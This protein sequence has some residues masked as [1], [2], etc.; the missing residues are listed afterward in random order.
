M[1]WTLLAVVGKEAKQVFC[2]FTWASPDDLKKIAVVLRKSGIRREN[3]IYER[4]LIFTRDQRK[5]KTADQYLAELRQIAANCSFES[6]T[7]DQLL[8]D[9]LV[10]GTR[11]AKRT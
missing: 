3:T 5:S 2:T 7:P 4:F 9:R 6:R 1:E 11:N 10:T 8:R